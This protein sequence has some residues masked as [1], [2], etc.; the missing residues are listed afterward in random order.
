MPIV[1]E[2]TP[3]PGRILRRTHLDELPQIWNGEKKPWIRGLWMVILAAL[4]ALAELILLACAVLQFGW[5]IFGKGPNRN[6]AD[7][8][9]KVGAW[10][11]ATA[12]YQTGVTEDRPWPWNEAR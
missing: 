4:F 2:I 9:V 3:T 1:P 8:G 5:Y 11:N 12:R 7:V 6:I 10:L